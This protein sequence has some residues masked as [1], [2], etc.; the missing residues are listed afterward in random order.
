[1]AGRYVIT[2]DPADCAVNMS[3]YCPA[4]GA[5]VEAGTIGDTVID[6]SSRGA[7]EGSAGSGGIFA[8]T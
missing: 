7:V 8:C 6:D 2:V 3:V 5:V 1:M 4:C